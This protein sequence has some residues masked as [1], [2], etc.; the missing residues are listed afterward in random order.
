MFTPLK[1]QISKNLLKPSAAGY[2]SKTI[3]P[4]DLSGEITI[5]QLLKDIYGQFNAMLVPELDPGK[6]YLTTSDGYFLPPN[7]EVKQIGIYEMV[8]T[9]T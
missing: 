5:L 7:C 1:L 3:L 9:T 4:V 6:I 8:L 2:V